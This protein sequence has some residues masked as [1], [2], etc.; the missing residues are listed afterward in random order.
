MDAQRFDHLTRTL[1]GRQSRRNA[2]RRAGAAASASLL[3]AAGI[4]PDQAAALIQAQSDGQPLFT[5]IRRYTLAGPTGDVRQA[6]QQGYVD[7]ACKAPGFVA[8]LTVEDDDGDFVTVAVFRSQNDLANFA[9]GEAQWIAQNL[10]DLLPA[11]DEAISGDT[12]IHAM[13]PQGFPNT[14]QAQPAPQP[15][16]QPAQPTAVPVQ[17]TAAPA[18]PTAAP[19]QPTA[20]PSQPTAVPPQPTPTAVPPC[21]GQ[22]CVCTTGTQAPCD[23]GLVCC[24]TTDLFGGPGVCQPQ[25]VCYPNNCLE[26]GAACPSS[27][28]VDEGCPACCSNYCNSNGLCDTFVATCD[29][30]GP[31][32]CPGGLICCPGTSSA[33]AA[34]S[35]AASC[36]SI[37]CRGHYCYCEGGVQGACPDGLICCVTDGAPG[38]VGSCLTEDECGPT[39][40]TGE[41]CTCTTGVNGACDA[42]LVCCGMTGGIPGDNGACRTEAECNTPCS[43]QGC[44]CDNTNPASCDQGL[45]CCAVQSGYICATAEQ[46]G[47]TPCTGVGCDCIGGTDGGCDAGLICCVQ[48]DPGAPG[49]CQTEDN[50]AASL[51]TGDGC[52][53]NGGVMNACQPGLICC[54]SDPSVPGGPGVCQSESLPCGPTCTDNGVGCV[55]GCNWGDTCTDCCSGFCNSSGLCDGFTPSDTCIPDGVNCGNTCN[56]SDG[57]DA[58]CSGFC[59][60]A[61]N[62][63]EP[64]ASAGACGDE[65]C[66]C[67][68]GNPACVE[69][70][71]C[72]DDGSGVTGTCLTGC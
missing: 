31:N 72:C 4:R 28:G 54:Q 32:T 33:G 61:G 70:L 35:T 49:A 5:I 23:S 47:L 22:G 24:P 67:Q 48:G 41:G 53:C 68:L 60:G 2:L 17:P 46:C 27:C 56:W 58:C 62:C 3:A 63:N 29:P 10:D 66:G 30:N 34:C 57:C 42:G 44:D 39:T 40:C 20:A 43:G 50:C 14:C 7:D 13:A 16:P 25:N 15:Q 36:A 45:V 18:Q 55:A 38:G 21:T 64:G 59:D 52:P 6:L 26:N 19:V 9:N 12:Y 69:G 8:Y 1:A 65:G 71:L 51:C 11:P 37:P